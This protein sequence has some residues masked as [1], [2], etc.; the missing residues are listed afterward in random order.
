MK[1]SGA[2]SPPPADSQATSASAFFDAHNHLQDERFSGRQDELLA[3]T[4]AEGVAA[5]VVNGSCEGDWAAGAGLAQRHP[6]LVVPGFGYH[7]W[8]LGER[9]PAWRANLTGFLDAVPGAVIG[10]IGL[11]RW[12]L[13]NPERWRTYRG[14]ADESSKLKAQSSKTEAAQEP[15]SFAEQ[16]EAFI[17]QFR[18]AAE[19]NVAASIHCLQAFGRL[20]EL[21]A[22]SPRP[23]R[24]FL[25]HSYGGPVEMVPVFAKLGAYFSF[26]GYFLHERKARQR[27]TFRAVPPDRL[28]VETDAPDQLPPDEFIRHPFQAAHSGRALNHPANL[29]AI[30]A[31]L[32]AFLRESPGSLSIRVAE[33]FQRL[34]GR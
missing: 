10:E 21:L 8:Y 25:L 28:L 32:A 9:T 15:P 27:E 26:P 33:N 7:P 16:E 29:P 22:A 5:M 6:G 34:F 2:M 3:S 20:R 31:G 17:W 4:R 18:L 19:R 30:Q 1:D 14:E 13:E 11:D 12:M 24:G 23:A